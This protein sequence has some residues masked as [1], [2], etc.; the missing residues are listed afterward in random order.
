MAV[1]RKSVTACFKDWPGSPT[2]LKVRAIFEKYDGELIGSG[3]MLETGERDV[4]YKL[5]LAKIPLA[6]KELVCEVHN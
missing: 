1:K 6:R 4:E 2:D 3:T 5:P